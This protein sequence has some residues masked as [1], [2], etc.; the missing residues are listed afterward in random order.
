MIA[1]DTNI[2]VRFLADDDAVQHEQA[3]RFLTARNAEDPAFVSSVTLAETVWVLHRRLKFPISDVIAAIRDLLASDG[4][5]IEHAEEL[6]QLL[7]GEKQPG[8][9]IADYLIAW[10]AR[11]AGCTRTVTMDRRAANSIPSMELLA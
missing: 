10:A 5:V 11:A 6:G 1:I 9:D 8:A 2:L 7:H 3:K 4:V